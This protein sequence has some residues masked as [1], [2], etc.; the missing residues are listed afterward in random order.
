MMMRNTTSRIVCLSLCLYAGCT[1]QP[2]SPTVLEKRSPKPVNVLQERARAFLQRPIPEGMAYAPDSISERFI[3]S[4]AA[5]GKADLDAELT[6]LLGM[7]AT[8]ARRA[9]KAKSGGE[10]ACFRESGEIL[11][12]ILNESKK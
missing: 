12:L 9:A 8:E 11:G 5:E 2:S 6:E 3:A 10:A 1:Q 7:C 4:Y